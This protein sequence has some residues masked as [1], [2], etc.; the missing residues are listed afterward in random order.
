MTRYVLD[1]LAAIELARLGGDVPAE[2]RLVGPA[3]LR[4]DTLRLL[5]QA[6]RSGEQSPEE[7]RRLLDR[8][9]TM[10]I[11]LLNDRVS[12]GTAWRIADRLGWDD[13]ADAEYLAVTQLQADAFV[14]LDRELAA[15]VGD[16]VPLA[17]LD[18]V[19]ASS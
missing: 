1:P 19:T 11:R 5:Y 18:A 17:P 6:V 9:T 3:R 16:L 8:I 14:T 12:R 15:R 10:P 13:T 4:S 7:G 2:H